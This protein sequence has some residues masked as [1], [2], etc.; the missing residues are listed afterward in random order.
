MYIH[1]HMYCIVVLYCT[2]LY[3]IYTCIDQSDLIL[4]YVVEYKD[5]LVYNNL[6]PDQCRWM[7]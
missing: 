2:V 4:I 5:N 1:V 3:C 7:G 6:L